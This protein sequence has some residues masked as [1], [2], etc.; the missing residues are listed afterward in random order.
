MLYVLLCRCHGSEPIARK[1]MRES[2]YEAWQT[3]P[4][5]KGREACLNRL[6]SLPQNKVV[7]EI[8]AYIKRVSSW[9]I[10]LGTDGE[11]YEWAD[12]GHGKLVD[13]VDAERI[14]EQYG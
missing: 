6:N 8:K 2:H 10:I 5:S 1:I 4:V 12:A 11:N 9:S 7:E 13:R 14:V 3:Q